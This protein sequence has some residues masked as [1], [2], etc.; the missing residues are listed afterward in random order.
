MMSI[1]ADIDLLRFN[2]AGNLSFLH[3]SFDRVLLLLSSMQ[4]RPRQL[5]SHSLA[6]QPLKAL[7]LFEKNQRFDRLPTLKQYPSAAKDPI[8]ETKVQRRRRRID[9]IRS[10]SASRRLHVEYFRSND[11]TVGRVS[12]RR[13]AG[14]R[15]KSVAT[16]AL[17]RLGEISSSAERSA[18][19]TRS[20]RSRQRR[21]RL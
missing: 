2:R 19:E 7:A 10:S 18:C 21:F 4:K 16:V 6:N 20:S 11:E 14:H 15:R 17:E 9:S 3:F 1:H 12:H 8:T 13:S 5:H